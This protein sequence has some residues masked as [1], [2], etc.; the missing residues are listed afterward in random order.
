MPLRIP[1]SVVLTAFALTLT[2]APA[3]SIW[4]TFSDVM[5]ASVDILQ[6]T[7]VTSIVDLSTQLQDL[8]LIRAQQGLSVRLIDAENEMVGQTVGIMASGVAAMDL[9]LGVAEFA[10]FRAR[11]SLRAFSAARSHKSFSYLIWS[12]Y[13]FSSATPQGYC[14]WSAMW[15]A[16]NLDIA[17]NAFTRTVYLGRSMTLAN[18]STAAVL[19]VDYLNQSTGNLLMTFYTEV[20]AVPTF[21]ASAV[22]TTAKWGT[23]MNFNGKTGQV[24]VPFQKWIP[25]TAPTNTS[26]LVGIA[27]NTQTMSQE[28]RE[29][30]G[31]NSSANRLFV[32]FRQPHGHLIAASHG[33]FHSASDTDLLS[34][35]PL[36]NPPDVSKFRLFTCL[37]STDILIAQ[38]CWNL[39]DTY[40]TWLA[41]PEVRLEM[42]LN[43]TKYWVAVS[44]GT[45]S[46]DCILVMLQ[47]KEAIVGRAEASRQKVT[48]QLGTKR[49]GTYVI[50][51]VTCV[52]G[53]FLPL[54]AGLWL[55]HQF[56]R[57]AA[58]M[59]HI[60]GLQ[61]NPVA[62]PPSHFTELHRFQNSF[63]KM[64]RGLRAFSKFVPQG[65]VKVLIMGSMHANDEMKP[66]RLT[67]MFADIEGFSTICET[68]SP[69]AL[70]ECC[71]D[72][73]ETMCRHIVERGG[74]IDKFIGDCI[75]AFWNA[76]VPQAH[77]ERT[78]VETALAMQSSVHALHA[79]WGAVGLPL[80]KFRL[81]IHT[82]DCLLGNFGCSYRVSYTCLGDSVNL[83][84]RLEAL[85]KKFG[86]Y[87]CIS[88]AT[89]LAAEP[90][91]H[92]RYLS[93]VTVPGKA[94]VLPVYEPLYSKYSTLHKEESLQSSEDQ[95][96]RCLLD[97]ESA[98]EW[99]HSPKLSSLPSSMI[100]SPTSAP[101]QSQLVYHWQYVNHSALAAHVGRYEAAYKFLTAGDHQAASKLLAAGSPLGI[102]DKAWTLLQIQCEQQREK[103][104]AHHQPWDGVFYFLEK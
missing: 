38:A 82:G 21:L 19:D 91:F 83:A 43:G 40:G 81:G 50:L 42:T 27:I 4:V 32:F 31:G 30:L 35:N 77:H 56:H 52:I 26:L 74:T 68:V 29:V 5:T 7:A 94:E 20:I 86:T 3:I 13:Q 25:S 41:I 9:R 97:L 10:D 24:E 48:A 63:T 59:D 99:N 72:Y 78:A 54:T 85:N 90:Y 95:G 46:L 51:A 61:F 36:T 100:I 8:L 28:L 76:P 75:M 79:Q 98:S 53:F 67:I 87:I 84:S 70:A 93:K 80:L 62:L 102:A 47:N 104:S 18:D 101:S 45:T 58:S 37:N 17:S 73:F 39:V 64:E 88:Y 1:F 71:L 6:S 33:K 2:M 12:A 49:A 16:L 55:A 60:A 65:V 15:Q 34:I 14:L 66:H 11:H 69:A 23:D 89:Y 57:I 44:Y 92:F 103:S 22:F 96:Q